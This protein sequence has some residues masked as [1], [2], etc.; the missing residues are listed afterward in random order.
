[1]QFHDVVTAIKTL[2]IQGAEG[3]AREGVEALLLI[4][5]GSHSVTREALLAELYHARDQLVAARPT[6]PCLRNALAYVFHN[7]HSYTDDHDF[8]Q[9]IQDRIREVLFYFDASDAFISKFGSAKIRHG[10]IVYTHCHSSTVVHVLIA[11]KKQ[12]KKFVV[13]NTETRPLYQGRRTATELAAAGIPVVHY[14]DSAGRLAMKDA[15]LC[16]LGSDAITYDAV[17]NKVGSGMFA[18]LLHT[19]KIPLYVCTNSWKFDPY[20]TKRHKEVVEERSASEIW[21]GSSRGITIEDPAFEPIILPHVSAII[22]E[23]GVLTPLTFL[24][25]VKKKYSWM[26]K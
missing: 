9:G 1:M 19:R 5:K 26:G 16:L 20:A 7:I 22:S 12:G 21:K 17:Y 24:K 11:A 25:T 18:E 15:H 2:H 23:L 8:Y 14:V 3:V 4:L 13:H 6:E 10:S